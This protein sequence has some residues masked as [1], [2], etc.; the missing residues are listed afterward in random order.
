MPVSTIVGVMLGACLMQGT[1][2]V[3]IPPAM[4]VSVVV[5][6]DLECE[7]LSRDQLA[8][9]YPGLRLTGKQFVIVKKWTVEPR[10]RGRG[11]VGDPGSLG[12][13][14][15]IL[16]VGGKAVDSVERF[17]LAL[18]KMALPGEVRIEFLDITQARRATSTRESVVLLAKAPPPVAPTPVAPPAAAPPAAAPPAMLPIVNVVYDKFKDHTELYLVVSDREKNVDS[19]LHT[20]LTSDFQ[21]GRWQERPATQLV[22][23]SCSDSWLFLRGDRAL[24]MIQDGGKPVQLRTLAYDS[25]VSGVTLP[26]TEVLIWELPATLFQQLKQAKLV[27]C[28][29]GNVEFV[30][31]PTFGGMLTDFER[32]VDSL[33][34][35]VPSSAPQ[36][37]APPSAPQPGAPQVP[38]A[39]QP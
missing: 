26:C 28:K 30:L 29:V 1:P 25:R 9:R 2:K 11:G 33:A 35:V 20:R 5:A 13:G 31:P 22:M 36:P 19:Y 37:N 14:D 39:T 4:R 8:V 38:P 7:E 21:G 6:L 3:P 32:K 24:Y 15:V 16:K 23:G 10:F 27:E 17:E 18:G 34:E 12:A